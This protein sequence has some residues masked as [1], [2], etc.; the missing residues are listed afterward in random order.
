MS[1]KD[2]LKEDLNTFINCNEFA[3]PHTFFDKTINIVIATDEVERK[4]AITKDTKHLELLN[5]VS[6]L[7]YAKKSD[8]SILPKPNQVTIFDNK[9]C[10]V[11]NVAETDDVLEIMLSYSKK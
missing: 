4:K 7:F 8:F 1:F 9:Q 6:V 5:N 10:R 11:V 2:Y 3:E